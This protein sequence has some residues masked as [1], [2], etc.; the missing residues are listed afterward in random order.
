MA[1]G[2]RT[3]AAPH[4]TKVRKVTLRSA[5]ALL[6]DGTVGVQT[7]GRRIAVDRVRSSV[8]AIVEWR[9]IAPFDRAPAGPYRAILVP[10]SCRPTLPRAGRGPTAS[11]RRV[12]T[13][14]T[15]GS[16]IFARLLGARA[17]HERYEDKKTEPRSDAA[18]LAALSRPKAA[19]HTIAWKTR[20][21]SSSAS[22]SRRPSVRAGTRRS[23]PCG[24][25]S[26]CRRSAPTAPVASRKSSK[27]G[28]GRR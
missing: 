23:A 7:P 4:E 16:S 13:A 26:C 25:R 20:A 9:S 19:E 17:G 8:A 18:H 21:P 6:H 24:T 1:V 28:W 11:G 27:C 2:R 3:G 5:A 10:N 15:G 22:P 14:R 12:L